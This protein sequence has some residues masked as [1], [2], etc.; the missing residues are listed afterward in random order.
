MGTQ[1]FVI[2]G[3]SGVGKSTL[4]K[5]LREQLPDIGYC[6]S[7]TSR[8]KRPGEEDGVNYHF[9]TRDR[10]QEMIRKGEFV[11][12]EEIYG[13][14]YG[15]S[16]GSI[17]ELLDKGRDVIMDIDPRG[18]KNIKERYEESILI[19]ILP[20]SMDELERRIRKRATEKE[21]VINERLQKALGEIKESSWYD[22]MVINENIEDTVLALRS[23]IVSNRLRTKN[24]IQKVKWIFSL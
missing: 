7:H 6:V 18:A 13:E 20:P 11:E 3:P 24:M 2:S 10:F 15:T 9:I 22:Y 14:L 21:Q 5:R 8:L 17:T 1:L 19:F 4:I 23:I 12:W 16:Y